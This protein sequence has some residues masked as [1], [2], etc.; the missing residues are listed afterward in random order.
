[1]NQE[2][3]SQASYGNESDE[4]DESEETQMLVTT[5]SSRLLNP[6]SSVRS[7][8]SRDSSLEVG[9]CPKNQKQDSVDASVKLQRML[10]I[11]Q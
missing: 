3:S 2:C 4:K 7:D 6:D 10:K 9:T 8:I 5:S 11:M 1:M